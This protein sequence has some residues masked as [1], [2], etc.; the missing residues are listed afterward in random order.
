QDW[1]LEKQWRQVPGV[2]DVVSF[3]GH[4]KQYHV[5]I[6]PYRLKG[7][8]VTLSQLT[9]ALAN[10][11]QNVGGQRLTLGEQSFNVR[12][13]GLI[14]S[15]R[16][17]QQIVVA[18]QKGVPVRVRDVADVAE[19]AAPRLGIVGK[20]LEPDVV[21]GIVLMRYGGDS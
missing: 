2:I 1:I 13:L 12:G 16:D 5:E 9:S 4:T 6:D 7:Q 17:V 20:D 8:E 3:G 18:A 14:R 11:N 15:L 21:Q 19:G 10:A